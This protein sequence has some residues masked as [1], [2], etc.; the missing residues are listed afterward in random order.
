MNEY[1]RDT[2]AVIY[3]GDSRAVLPSLAESVDLIVTDPPYGQGYESNRRHRSALFDKIAGDDGSVDVCEILRLSL[4]ILKDKRHLYIFGPLDLS[5]LPLTIVAE[6][7]WDKAQVGLGN[8]AQPWAL[9]HEPIQFT[10]YVP[11]KANRAAGDGGLAARLRRGSVIR[12]KRPNSR[13]VNRHPTEKPIPLL[14]QLVESSS[15]LGETVFDP[16]A[17][18]GSTLVAS[19][20]SG[21]RAVGIELEERYCEVAAKRLLELAPILDA[22]EKV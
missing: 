15:L 2:R 4:R 17:G 12:C 13:A 1:Y 9:A 3:H 5:P 10:T 21:R 19:A 6:L 16:F 20:I 8:L 7:I 22:L 11:S 18:S 14:R